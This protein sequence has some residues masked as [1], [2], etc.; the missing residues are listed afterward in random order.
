MVLLDVVVR[1]HWLDV[2][3]R[4]LTLGF[5]LRH[6]AHIDLDLNIAFAFFHV[7]LTILRSAEL[8]VPR[9]LFLAWM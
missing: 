8:C 1:E 6:A 5:L 9:A 2:V 3:D 4:L 7:Y